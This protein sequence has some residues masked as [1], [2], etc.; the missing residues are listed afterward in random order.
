MLTIISILSVNVIVAAT[1][2]TVLLLAFRS[3]PSTSQSNSLLHRMPTQA[4]SILL[5]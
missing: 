1:V 4:I 2:Y 3:K 5:I